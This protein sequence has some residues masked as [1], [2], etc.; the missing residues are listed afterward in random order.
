MEAPSSH[1][2][3]LGTDKRNPV[4]SIYEDDAQENLHV[5]YGF[6]L[7]EVVPNEREAPALK[8]L[9]ARLYNAG[10]NARIL[11]ATFLVDRKTMQRWGRALLSGDP[12]ELSRVLAGR[13]AGR[14]LTPEIAAYVRTR[15]PRI[16]GE[17]R[18][19][20][21]AR[22]CREIDS[23][24]GVQLTTETL[25][26][27]IGQ[28]KSAA[29]GSS[30]S[31]AQPGVGVPLPS[32]AAAQTSGGGE[33]LS[34]RSGAG[35][36]GGDGEEKRETACEC[37]PSPSLLVPLPEGQ[38]S[39]EEL[40]GAQ[41]PPSGPPK[42]KASPVL[43]FDGPGQTRWC[44]HVGVLLF[45]AALLKVSRVIDPPEPLFAQWLASL[46]LG[47]LN[48]E[49][50][51]FL[52]WED[53][54]LMLGTVVRF[55]SPQRERL[56]DL[57]Q[58]EQI[59][60]LLRWNSQLLA[61]DCGSDF[62]FDPH[63]KHYTGEQNVLKG[64]C[65]GIRLADKA[66][67]TDFVH[68]VRGEPIYFETTDNFEDLRQRFF[69]VTERCR[70]GL[71]WPPDRVVTWVV[72]RGIFGAE[73]F[74]RVLADPTL[75]LI[76]WQKGYVAQEWK[77]EEVSGRLV[78]ERARNHA[79]DLR[80]Y[81]F[82]YVDRDWASN[83]RLR[84]I[85]VRAT[86]PRGRTV[87]VA[88][89]TDDRQRAVEQIVRLIFHRWIQE[90]DFKYLDKH[91]G[92]NQLTSYRSLPYERLKGQL[93]DREQYS[94]QYKAL[95]E[96]RRQG[97]ARQARLLLVHERCAH[98]ARQ[99]QKQLAELE[100]RLA[101]AAPDSAE[102]QSLSQRRHKLQAAQRQHEARRAEREKQIQEQSEQLGPLEKQLEAAGKKVSRLEEMIAANMVRMEPQCKRLMDTL[103]IIARNVFYVALRPFKRAYNNY[104]D[105]HDNFRQLTQ[106]NGVLEVGEQAIT[107]HLLP[108][109]NYSPK[110]QRIIGRLLE[111]LNGQKPE[112]PD[113]TQRRLQFRL[114][115]RSELRLRMQIDAPQS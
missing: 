30:H 81:H 13:S 29:I 91:F 100:R 32:R 61:Q 79:L 3:I 114:A 14:K 78:M 84:Q 73:V 106:A 2:L 44:D 56:Q 104:R 53:L 51:K 69:A 59:Q 97:R 107:V 71:A 34:G 28:L 89:L 6:E 31:A 33:G 57:A 21:S 62:Y 102:A 43:P 48:I 52:N 7:M 58:E 54:E 40:S 9:V 4:I 80:S 76:T 83:P 67:H 110:L 105:D 35:E 65:P 108:Q 17:S 77:T 26:P 20:C 46:L 109:V 11:S 5:Y 111:D 22:L 38:L 16:A 85:V 60:A 8:L 113:G 99:R 87:Q 75:H 66:L 64:W 115:A 41:G 93:T 18:Y 101:G 36:A 72:D 1:Q 70:K 10:V 96:E 27:L 45:W 23:V 55:P 12:Q 68:T 42:P 94:G 37:A 47:A 63:T 19:A 24:F 82:E 88:I 103:K 90:N 92:I 86:N 98:T 95:R 49:Q 25:R 74:E 15:W 39:T 112:M 50:T